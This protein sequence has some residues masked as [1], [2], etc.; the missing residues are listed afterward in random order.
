MPQTSPPGARADPTSEAPLPVLFALHDAD[1]AYWLNTAVAI[2]SLAVHASRPVSIHVIHDHSL[3]A[4]ARARLRQIAADL[5]TPLRFVAATLPS[6]FEAGRLPP[7]FSPR[8][9]ERYS[10]ASLFRLM[11]PELFADEDLVV[12]LDSDLVLNGLDVHELAA[13]TPA[14]APLAA[15]ADPFIGRH[16]A[17]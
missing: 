10:P 9:L 3:G 1:G 5:Q 12:Y 4:V 15:V 2:T 11:I 13:A 6:T 7:G 8:L 14:D 17:R 16:E